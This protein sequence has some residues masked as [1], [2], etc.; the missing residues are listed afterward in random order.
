[1]QFHLHLTLQAQREAKAQ[2]A[3]INERLGQESTDNILRL[4]RGAMFTLGK[5]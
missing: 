2:S 5:L 3:Q 1:V 4:K